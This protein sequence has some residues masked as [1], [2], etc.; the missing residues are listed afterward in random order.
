MWETGWK[1]VIQN[2]ISD[3]FEAADARA[4]GGFSDFV[5]EARDRI[6]E[7]TAAVPGSPLWTEMKEN[8]A[9][10]SLRSDGLGAMQLI[11]KCVSEAVSKLANDKAGAWEL[12]VVAH[13]A[14]SIFL[15]Y[16]LEA[17][18]R[19]GVPIRTVQLIAPAIRLDLF[20]QKV[21]PA[22]AGG[23]CPAPTVYVLS[24]TGEL[25][26]DVGPYGK[27]LLYLVSRAFEDRRDTPLA[28]MKYWIDRASPPVLDLLSGKSN[29]RP[30]LVVS[31]AVAAADAPAMVGSISRSDSHG[32]FDNDADTMN[33]VLVR[34]LNDLPQR[35]FD[36]RD[37]RF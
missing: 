33:S 12:H 11:T 24:E 29:G 26:D 15:A 10:A 20:E 1:E 18:A 25:D 16:A 3:H 7:L 13:S 37:L 30:N 4:R 35:T 6:L 34:I 22:V 8:A 27:S 5:S 36:S 2:I 19:L 28:G 9:L 17:L 23:V 31:G 14:G 21:L 32:G